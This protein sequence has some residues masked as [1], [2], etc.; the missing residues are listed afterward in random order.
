M[1]KRIAIDPNVC[2]GKPVIR[3]TRVLVA[4]ILVRLPAATPLK[5]CWK[6]IPASR[7]KTFWRRLRSA[8]S[9]RSSK[10]LLMRRPHHEILS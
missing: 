10:K 9:Y 4:N 3:G 5:R 1:H 8:E 2:H 6:T 7:G